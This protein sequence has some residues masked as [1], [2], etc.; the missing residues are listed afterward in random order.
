MQEILSLQAKEE[1][2]LARDVL[3]PDGR[4]LCGK[5]TALTTAIIDRIL[6][7][8]ISHVAVEGHP[9]EIEGEKSLEQELADI[10]KRFSRVT[11]IQPLQY[12]KQRLMHL[13]VNARK[14]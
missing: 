9:V 5:G 14:E 4:V 12:I 11:H 7:M 1:M 3:T 8:D 13:A 2:V 10:Q 6:K